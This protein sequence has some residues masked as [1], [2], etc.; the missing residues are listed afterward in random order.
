MKKVSI[1]SCFKR[2]S[3]IAATSCVVIYCM[4]V[5]KTKFP[6]MFEVVFFVVSRFCCLPFLHSR[7]EQ[8]TAPLI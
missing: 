6:G 7:K 2:S 5:L 3:E 8:F 1:Y 4:K